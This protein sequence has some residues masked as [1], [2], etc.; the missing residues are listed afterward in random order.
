MS[1]LIERGGVGVSYMIK[2]GAKN[3]AAKQVWRE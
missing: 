2:M 1:E 3:R